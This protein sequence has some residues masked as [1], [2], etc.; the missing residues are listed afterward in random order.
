M[1]LDPP[2]IKAHK[3]A[4][5][6]IL[7]ADGIV[8][9][10]GSLYTSILPNLL[11]TDLTEAI[12]R[13]DGLK[14]FICN[15][16]TQPGETD[17]FTASDHIQVIYDHIG[18]DLFH[19]IMMNNAVP[20]MNIQ[21]KYLSKNQRLVVPDVDKVQHLGCQVIVNDFILDHSLLRHDADKISKE[22][23]QLIAK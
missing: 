11:V 13:S 6:A 7:N 17:D 9:A 12:R 22:I 2:N 4:I 3:Q 15:I 23:F 8:I 16:M 14:I 10:P 5:D 19:V 18:D 21:E 20:P 1:F